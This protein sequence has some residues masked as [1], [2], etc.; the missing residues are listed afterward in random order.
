MKFF[1]SNME[2]LGNRIEGLSNEYTLVKQEAKAWRKELIFGIN[3]LRKQREIYKGWEQE[4]ISLTEQKNQQ[5]EDKI[6]EIAD[7]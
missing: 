2:R 5:L 1:T 7:R 6:S 3:G 4:I